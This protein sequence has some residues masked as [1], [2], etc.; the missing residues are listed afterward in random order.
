MF[1]H[2]RYMTKPV[3][4]ACTIVTDDGVPIEVVHLAGQG[5]LGIV[6]AHGFAQSWQR[7]GV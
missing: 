1:P 3:T 4:K 5:D 2:N 6:L 7:P